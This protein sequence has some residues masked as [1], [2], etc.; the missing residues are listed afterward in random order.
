[1]SLAYHVYCSRHAKL[2]ALCRD[3]QGE[4]KEA[5]ELR[6]AMDRL[7]AQMSEADRQKFKGRPIITE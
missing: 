1:M 6:E 3:G 4:S 2:A 7:W 5:D